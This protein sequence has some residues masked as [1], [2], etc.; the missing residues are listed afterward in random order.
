MREKTL[1]LTD[2]YGEN[3]F[4]YKHLSYD[5]T[6]IT[7]TLKLGEYIYGTARTKISISMHSEKYY[8]VKYQ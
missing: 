1:Q 8:S 5:H 3:V 2:V 6:N 7:F 4:D